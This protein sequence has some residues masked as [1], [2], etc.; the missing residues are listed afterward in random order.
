LLALGKST[1]W[2][3]FY[4]GGTFK[5]GG[6]TWRGGDA[7]TSQRL[8]AKP[9]RIMLARFRKFDERVGRC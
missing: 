5:A 7:Q 3:P 9:L 4:F 8:I 2:G 6:G 1:S